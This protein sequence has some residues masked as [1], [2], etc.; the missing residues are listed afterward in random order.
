MILNRPLWSFISCPLSAAA[1]PLAGR[2]AGPKEAWVGG[3]L[4]S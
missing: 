3:P 4:A 2:S 1:L